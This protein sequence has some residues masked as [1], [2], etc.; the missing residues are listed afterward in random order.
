MNLIKDILR[1][2]VIGV[3]NIIPGVSGG[4]MAVSMGIYDK[5][6]YAVN[7]VRTEFKKSVL[8]LL[9][10]VIG[11]GINLGEANFPSEL[12]EIATSLPVSHENKEALLREILAHLEDALSESADSIVSYLS[13]N[14]VILGKKVRFFGA[15]EGEG[16]AVGLDAQGGLIVKTAE[17]EILTLTTGEISVRLQ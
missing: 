6:I 16:V 1:G 17:N 12:A 5:M 3:A 10:Y 15:R 4:T 11:M 8:T 14:S 9:P 13:E 7:H 2:V